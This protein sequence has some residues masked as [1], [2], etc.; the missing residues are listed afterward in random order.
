MDV[1]QVD[2]HMSSR[3]PQI[4]HGHSEKTKRPPRAWD[5]P[6][7]ATVISSYVRAGL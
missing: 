6:E 3:V 2:T 1:G 5:T 4:G 7:L